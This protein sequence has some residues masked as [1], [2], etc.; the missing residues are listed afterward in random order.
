MKEKDYYFSARPAAS[1]SSSSG[2]A[3]VVAPVLVEVAG[4]VVVV[5]RTGVDEARGL[6]ILDEVAPG[7][8]LALVVGVVELGPP[9]VGEEAG[10][11]LGLA[12]P[13]SSH[14]RTDF[15]R[16]FVG[17]EGRTRPQEKAVD[18]LIVI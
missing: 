15:V 5:I 2:K 13:E 1:F 10:E 18:T 4:V 8:G 14:H 16:Q 3:P 9:G 17:R 6:G 11:D 7:D 12:G